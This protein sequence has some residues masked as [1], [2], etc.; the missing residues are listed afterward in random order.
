MSASTFATARCGT[1]LSTASCETPMVGMAEPA[2]APCMFDAFAASSAAA[3]D[4]A[5]DTAVSIC[6]R[7]SAVIGDWSTGAALA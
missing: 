3:I 7:A 6:D 1:A 4:D 2:R 5:T